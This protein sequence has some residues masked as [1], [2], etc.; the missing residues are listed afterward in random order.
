MPKKSR[1]RRAK[2][3]MRMTPKPLAVKEASQH[4]QPLPLP[5][6]QAPVAKSSV[7]MAEQAAHHRYVLS[8]LRRSL[9]ISAVL[10]VLLIV[11]YFLL[12]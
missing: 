3:R 1:K 7:M 4:P 12:R 11:L 9:T 2:R 8:D 6:K 5:P 10:F